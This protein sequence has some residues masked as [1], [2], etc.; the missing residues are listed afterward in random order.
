MDNY[1]KYTELLSEISDISHATALLHWDLETYMP[2]NGHARRAQQIGTLSKLAH[3]KITNPELKK[4]VDDLMADL[5]ADAK[6]ASNIKHSARDLKRKTL[7]DDKFVEEMSRATSEAFFHWQKAKQENDFGVYAPFLQKVIDLKRKE[8][9]IVGFKD[10]PYDALC[11][12]YEPDCTVKDI[13]GIFEGVKRDL[14]PLLDAI[15]S[16]P[17]VD[18]SFMGQY[19]NHDKQWNFGIEVLKDMGYDFDGGR[20]D[21]SSHPF[22]IN[23]AATDVRVTTRVSEETFNEM[24]WSCIH[25]GGHALYEQGLPDSEYGLPSGEAV[26]LGIHESQSRLWENNVGRSL[27]FWEWKFARLKE[28][29]P[30]Q[31]E[32]V[33]AMDFFKAMNKVQPSLIRVNADELTYHFHILIRYELEKAIME[34][35]LNANDL[36]AA[37]NAKYKEYLD[38]DVPNYSQGVLQDIHWSHGSIGYFPTYSIGSFYAA[39]FHAAAEKEIGTLDPNNAETYLKNLLSWL[40]ENIHQ[41]G[42]QYSSKELCERISGETLNSKFFMDYAQK[43]Y[44]LIY[45]I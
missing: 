30:A 27:E 42:K 24:L 10:H 25:E 8:A 28:I 34:E 13:D 36:P 22:T 40:R 4:L 21:I 26:S 2:K 14:K 7:F 19:F 32:G 43:K 44:G 35:K 39:Q 11:D 23:F 6:Q 29:F 17:Q 15:Q 41:Y 12:E 20:Q 31:F 33:S 37:W 1:T 5:P 9:K 3:Q 16:K 45:G 18:D 38:V